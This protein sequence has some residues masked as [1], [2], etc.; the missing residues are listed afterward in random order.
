MAGV[1]TFLVVKHG[2]FHFRRSA[3]VT[4]S[5]LYAKIPSTYNPA[6]H[7]DFPSLRLLLLSRLAHS[8]TMKMVEICSIETSGFLRTRQ[9]YNSEDCKLHI[10]PVRTSNAICPTCLACRNKATSSVKG[11]HKKTSYEEKREN[12][13]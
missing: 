11:T 2:E 8:L 9:R 13:C 6:L 12:G 7:D 3:L 5:A 1:T 4:H 10:S